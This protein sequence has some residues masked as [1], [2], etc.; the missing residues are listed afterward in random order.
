MFT[1]WAA[2]LE[3]GILCL[4]GDGGF[5]LFVLLLLVDVSANGLAE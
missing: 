3:L 2:I 5:F 4:C 1:Q